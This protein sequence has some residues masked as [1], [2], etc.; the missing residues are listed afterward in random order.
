ML[1][2]CT[3]VLQHIAQTRGFPGRI[4]Y[5]S[6]SKLFKV[7]WPEADPWGYFEVYSYSGQL[8]VSFQ[9]PDVNSNA[10]VGHL[11][12]NRAAIAHRATF[13]L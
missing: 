10:P 6:A 8:L 4:T 12:G 7:W 11:S 3:Y 13:S 2:T 5:S 9:D 1:D